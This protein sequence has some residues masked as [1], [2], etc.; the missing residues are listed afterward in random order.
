[1]L[2]GGSGGGVMSSLLLLDRRWCDSG[3]RQA[4]WDVCLLLSSPEVF[5]YRG[6]GSRIRDDG[7]YGIDGDFMHSGGNIRSLIRLC[8]RA[9]AS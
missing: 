7:T 2:H 8:R 4:V 5:D 3:G 1:M 9:S 6:I